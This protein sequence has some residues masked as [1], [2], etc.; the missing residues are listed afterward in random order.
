M[1]IKRKPKSPSEYYLKI[2]DEMAQKMLE[3]IKQIEADKQ[4][5]EQREEQGEKS[6]DE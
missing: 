6:D 3:V 1:F 2:E 5:Q 4:E